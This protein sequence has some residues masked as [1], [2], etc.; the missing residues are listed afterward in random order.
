MQD[1]DNRQM[2]V[3]HTLQPLPLRDY[4]DDDGDNVHHIH[5]HA[6][7]H[8]LHIHRDGAPRDHAHGGHVHGDVRLRSRRCAG[9]GKGDYGRAA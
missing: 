5:D 4:G 8:A 3:Y 2:S 9:C 1:D 6:L 7:H